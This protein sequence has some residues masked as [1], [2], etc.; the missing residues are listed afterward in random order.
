MKILFI[1]YHYWPP[2]FGGELKISIERFETLVRRG[3]EVTVLTSGVPGFL[4][5]EAINGVQIK[6]SP[7]I[8]DSRLGRGLRRF[9]FTLWAL[10]RM[11]GMEFDVLHHGGSG[12]VTLYDL[13]MGMS[14][15]NTL[16]HRKGAKAIIVHSLADSEGEVFGNDGFKT[17]IR[18]R[19]F[20]KMDC[21]V[22]V[23]PALHVGVEKVLPKISRL[24][25]CGVRDDVFV[26]TTNE[27][28]RHFRNENNIQDEEVVFSFLGAVGKRKGFDLL[29]KAFSD[30]AKD[31][32]NW[33]LWIIG[34]HN[35]QESQNFE[36]EGIEEML[37]PLQGARERVHFWGRIDDRTEMATI[38]GA[39][40]VFVFPS[41]KEGMGIAPMEAMACGVPVII[42][43]IPGI[44]DQASIEGVTG[45][46]IE[47][48]N[49]EALR[50]AMTELGNDPDLRKK[51]G[52]A[53][54]HRIVEQFGWEK[55][56]DEWESLYRAKN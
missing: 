4:R 44:T 25:V 48:N 27:L 1:S 12:G 3:H 54:H 10:A 11:R 46:Y 28:R 31:H 53:A 47:V 24:L 51:M 29:I 5:D 2:H 30:L 40:D 17:R 14:L 42:S 52:N 32:E 19:C 49:A 15:M 20:E 37:E 22:S 34:P 56:L 26:P 45:R 23:S 50:N 41:R 9:T 8:H 21:I 6:R 55:H 35:K 13:Y 38:L 33:Q 18:N 36:D 43:R 7:I 16:A 39:S